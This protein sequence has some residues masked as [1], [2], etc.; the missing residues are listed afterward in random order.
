[1]IEKNIA[2]IFRRHNVFEYKSP[3][4]Y[5]SVEDFQKV[6]AYVWLYA[7]MNKASMRDIT[8]TIV[9]TRHPNE[10]LRYLKEDW[11]CKISEPYSGVYIAKGFMI[12]VQI[13]ESKKLNKHE[14]LWLYSLQ[15]NVNAENLKAVLRAVAK[16]GK[17][18]RFG[19]YLN[20]LL[21]ANPKT[22]K[23]IDVMTAELREVF[24]ETGLADE[25]KAMGVEKGRGIERLWV[26][27]NALKKGLSMWDVAE[28]TGLSR[29][30]IEALTKEN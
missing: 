14:N 3:E 12:P 6:C 15:N 26:A 1:V 27:R 11:D 4:D 25:W 21:S 22:M 24:I 7:S 23:E 9:G 29:E 20:V 8:V 28:I 13:V 10:A 30:E 16:R 5:A 19:A 17:G 2:R 18:E